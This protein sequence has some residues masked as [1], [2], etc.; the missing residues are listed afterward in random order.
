MH[1]N[2]S[3]EEIKLWLD[4]NC[5]TIHTFQGKEADEVIITLGCDKKNKKAVTWASK[6]PN[7]L[8]VAVSRAKYR[9]TIIGDKDLWNVPY[10]NTAYYLLE[11]DKSH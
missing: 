4:N 6:K 11:K 8:N 2:N 1:L 5:G 7:I 10:F 3:K 9:I